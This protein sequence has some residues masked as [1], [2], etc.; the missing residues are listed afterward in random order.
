MLIRLMIP[1]VL[2]FTLPA[3][4]QV[5]IDPRALDPKPAAPVPPSPVTAGP[6]G[7]KP[8][9]SA[10]KPSAKP[11]APTRPGVDKPAA[12]KPQSTV[13]VAPGAPGQTNVPAAA[14]PPLVLPPPIA[15]PTRPVQPSAP[16]T[17]TADAPGGTEALAGG[18]RVT[19]GSG[20]SELNPA[21]EA[22]IRGL[23]RTGAGASPDSSFTVT[24]YA[25][26]T[27]EDPS[28]ARRLSLSRALAVRS[29]LI[30]Q[31]IVST[32]IY[33]K[34]LGPGLPGFAD[35]PADRADVGVAGNPIAAP[36]A[37]SPP[38]KPR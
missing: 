19:F 1:A 30:S 2:M 29:V 6:P 36:A 31:G 32:R 34:A 17:V 22:A 25:A 23:A 3:A 5:T 11:V 20:H 28:T 4:A 33:V 15:V 10:G 21:M 14:P 12:A 7:Q 16:P 35:G 9:A 13:R 8:P 38:V 26:G 18:L 27:P 37:A 24:S